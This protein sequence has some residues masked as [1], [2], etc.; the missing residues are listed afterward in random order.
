MFC[1]SDSVALIISNISEILPSISF[2]QTLTLK[3]AF[4]TPTQ[5]NQEV[6]WTEFD[7]AF[8]KKLK[9]LLDRFSSKRRKSVSSAMLLD[10]G[11][12]A[13]ETSRLRS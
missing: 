7:G 10:S 6:K 8:C 3:K 9:I 5:L 4:E 11:T 12:V 2:L 1:V 13:I